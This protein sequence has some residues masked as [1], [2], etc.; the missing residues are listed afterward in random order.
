MGIKKT[1]NRLSQM[2]GGRVSLQVKML[3][4]IVGFAITLGLLNVANVTLGGAYIFTRHFE[5]QLI[6][7]AASLSAELRSGTRAMAKFLENIDNIAPE[8]MAKAHNGDFGGLDTLMQYTATAAGCTGHI[9]LD[10]DGKIVGSSGDI[11]GVSIGDNANYLYDNLNNGRLYGMVV[12]GD[13]QVCAAVGR[14]ITDDGGSRT[15]MVCAVLCNLCSEEYLALVKERYQID[16]ALFEGTKMVK[17]TI[18]DAAGMTIDDKATIDSVIVAHKPYSTRRHVGD[19]YYTVH[20]EPIVNKAGNTT[21]VLMTGADLSRSVDLLILLVVTMLIGGTILSAIITYTSFL[22]VR[23]T[24]TRPI[25]N[26]SQ[27]A[28]RIAER[29]LTQ[30]VE[31]YNQG[32][33]ID[34]LSACVADMQDSLRETISEIQE[35]ATILKSTS[36]QLSNAAMGLSDD[37]TRQAANLEEIASSVEQMTS[38]IHQNTDTSR[39]TNDV[40]SQTSA[41]IDVI[42][43]L[44]SQSKAE[45]EKIAS[46]I[47]AIN[48]LV[49][50]TN[51]LSLNA[52]VEAARAGNMGRG[53]AVVAR[54]VGRLAEQTRATAATVA[55][56]AEASIGAAGEVDKKVDEIMPMMHRVGSLMKEITTS[57]IEQGKGAEQINTA[58]ADLNQTTQ[59]TAS[60]A[61]GI[62]TDAEELANSADHLNSIA[63]LFKIETQTRA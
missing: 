56:T 57:S 9:M 3:A 21:A 13:G 49:N 4:V 41:A 8:E 46:A 6:G 38:N 62:A 50:K 55:E 43:D 12:V 35:A 36:D 7:K 44:S 51:I 63:Q 19:I 22:Y 15:G 20:Y 54:E 47:R 34:Y 5:Q 14:E 2:K 26:I 27:S 59:R 48:D 30:E 24:I 16:I 11:P 60:N 40:M 29:D 53:F 58:I 61:E 33:E 28:S 52:S 39:A 1:I 17:T 10:A 37:A 31:V 25:R 18:E 32:D 45:S 23:K 42:G